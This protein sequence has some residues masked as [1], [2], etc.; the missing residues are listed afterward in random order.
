[1]KRPYPQLYLRTAAHIGIALAAF[2]L[3]G[4]IS[5]GLIAAWELRGYIETRHSS[6]G[7][8]AAG[9]LQ[10]DGRTALV[11]WL[12]TRAVIPADVSIYIL[13]DTGQ[14]I[15]DRELPEQ[16]A[17]FVRDSVIGEPLTPGSNFRPIR[18]APEL[19]GQNGETYTFL[20]LPKG[21]SL[22]GSPATIL[23]L[24]TVALLVI[25]S[26]AWLIARAI[27]RPVSELQL[28]VRELASG[29]I[30]ARVPASIS[31]RGDELGTL[32]ADFNSM[33]NQL[34]ELIHG[35]E[36]L[37]RE[38]SHELRS[39]L[40]RLQAAV[41]LAAQRNSLDTSEHERIEQEIERMNRVIGE[42]LRY[43][44]LEASV[45]PKQKLIRI[46]KLLKDL[47]TVEEIEATSRGSQLQLNTQKNLTVL[48][49]PELL[50]SG[51]ENI[52]RNA[53]R[54][55]P[56]GSKVEINATYNDTAEENTQAATIVVDI[57]DRGPGVEN[58]YLDSIFEPY[59]RVA[60]GA[61]D[62]DST[63]LGLAIV[64][65]VVERHAGTVVARP[66]SG[67]GLTVTVSIPAANLS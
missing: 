48:G 59:V 40:A 50:L 56:E 10:A 67:G 25:A 5:L 3:I 66:R 43:S 8:E 11:M 36:N 58:Q 7:E 33:A 15:L 46:D 65:R 60:S 28:A 1:M 19:V 17:E 20:V 18:L 27:T 14:D 12:H 22:W 41:A 32:A 9:I 38:M 57:S 21:I 47:V 42:M 64:K 52:L 26:V 35:R 30:T 53:I 4:A 44:S 13:D 24:F 23:G 2:V 6:L 31:A 61:H 34:S 51:F 45:P 62:N 16:Y 49:D 54:Y 29:D 39:P 37:L 55:A 63:G